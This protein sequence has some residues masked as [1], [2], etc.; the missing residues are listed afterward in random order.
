MATLGSIDV[1]AGS[2]CIYM[3]EGVLVMREGAVCAWTMITTITIIV[4]TSV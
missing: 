2:V 1:L 3:V 4:A